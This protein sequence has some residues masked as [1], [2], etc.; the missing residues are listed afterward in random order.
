MINAPSTPSATP[1]SKYSDAIDLPGTIATNTSVEKL[2]QAVLP[3]EAIA[4][5][6]LT[7][8]LL[9]LSALHVAATS[10]ESREE[11]IESAQSHYS[12]AVRDFQQAAKNPDQSTCDAVF[13][14]CHIDLVY[15]FALP[16][17][18]ESP[19][20]N[21]IDDLCQIL[22]DIQTSSPTTTAANNNNNSLSK[23]SA[24]NPF[25]PHAPSAHESQMPNTSQ[26]AI[27]ALTRLNSI[28][29]QQDPSHPTSTYTTTMTHLA[30][31]LKTL[32][33]SS[34]SSSS[35]NS[36]ETTPPLST[37][38]WTYHVP[39]E[40]LPLARQRRPFALVLLAHYA[41]MLHAMRASWWVGGWG[42]RVFRQWGVGLGGELRGALG[43]V[44]DATGVVVDG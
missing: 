39:A 27:T 19:S 40:F 16:L 2:W 22:T 3:H 30:S 28:L 34:S 21:P 7:H 1:P 11:S 41:V 36:E 43:W 29:S 12:Q 4:H 24:L 18:M 8:G 32:L 17:T 37:M 13:A 44:V 38:Q 14:M 42:A 9:A 10:D 23:E 35:S 26:L 20:N 33:C 15:A 31:S 5:P 6:F 25:L